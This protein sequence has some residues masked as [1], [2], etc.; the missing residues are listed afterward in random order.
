M[1][2]CIP[3][4]PLLPLGASKCCCKLLASFGEFPCPPPFCESIDGAGLKVTEFADDIRWLRFGKVS[5][6]TA[7]AACAA[8]DNKGHGCGESGMAGEVGGINGGL[9]VNGLFGGNPQVVS[10]I[11]FCKIL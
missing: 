6:A 1:A 11:S 9:G 5:D 8:A 2:C 10:I 7:C 4:S 3:F